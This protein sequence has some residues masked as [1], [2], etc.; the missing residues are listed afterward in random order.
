MQFKPE[1]I[2]AIKAGRKTQTRR[3]TTVNDAVVIADG[4][5]KSVSRKGRLQWEVGRT[6]SVCPGRGRQRQGLI[7]LEAIQSEIIYLISDSDAQS[8]GFDNALAFLR[9][10][11]GLYPRSPVHQVVWVLTFELM[12]KQP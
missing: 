10:W 11:R 1:M 5:I 4:K 7:R 12:A 8:E 9:Y 6:Y 3:P 2:E